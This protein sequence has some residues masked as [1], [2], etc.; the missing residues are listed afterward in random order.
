MALQELATNAV[1]YGSLS[2]ETGE[3]RIE[4]SLDASHIPPCLSL[5]WRER[6]GPPV[7]APSRRGFGTRLVERSLAQDLDGE[8]AI[9][10]APEGVVCRVV[11]PI[12]ADDKA[13]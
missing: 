10:F 11:A 8:V 5:T 9:E 2:N 4:W 12:V 7:N 13:V 1:K 3:V 6:G